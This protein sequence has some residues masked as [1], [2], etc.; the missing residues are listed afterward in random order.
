[1]RLLLRGL[2]D[3][4]NFIDDILEHTVDWSDNIVGLRELKQRLRQ[5]GLTAR[6]SKCMVGYTSVAL[7]GHNV[8]DGILTPN[9]DKAR[10]IVE[11]RRPE[12]KKQIRSY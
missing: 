4:D 2:K 9:Q 11:A 7:L 3:K 12:T 1:M 8:G 5:A 10:D 6:P